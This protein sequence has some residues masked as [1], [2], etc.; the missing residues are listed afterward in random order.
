MRRPPPG[1]RLGWMQ[2]P[3]SVCNANF[4]CRPQ[5]SLSRP[6]QNVA[7]TWFFSFAKGGPEGGA[8]EHLSKGG[9][10]RGNISP[11]P[12]PHKFATDM[13]F[14]E[15]TAQ[16]ESWSHYPDMEPVISRSLAQ[17]K[18]FISTFILTLDNHY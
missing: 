16:R 2:K 6:H 5:F 13:Y 9:V 4:F 11:T 10:V 15:W 18:V 17:L 7:I 8:P 1:K 14:V 12:Q 3:K